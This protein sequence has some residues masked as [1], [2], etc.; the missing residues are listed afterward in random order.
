[1][2]L[3]SWGRMKAGKEKAGWFCVERGLGGCEVSGNGLSGHEGKFLGKGGE[4]GA[5]CDG[6]G[7]QRRVGRDYEKGL[8]DLR[9]GEFSGDGDRRWA[10][11]CLRF[12]KLNG[13]EESE[14]SF[15]RKKNVARKKLRERGAWCLKG[16][17]PLKEGITEREKGGVRRKVGGLTL[18]GKGISW[19]EEGGIYRIGSNRGGLD[20]CLVEGN[21]KGSE[22]KG[23]KKRVKNLVITGPSLI[24]LLQLGGKKS[25][26]SKHEGEFRG[27]EKGRKN[28]GH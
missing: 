13:G 21:L 12:L 1:M 9:G 20:C 8:N 17:C 18:G 27:F 26:V 4:G 7:V 2:A 28:W 10:K 6:G 3:T 5:C 14:A 22:K 25:A 15:R 19:G 11:S 16:V 24:G 23:K